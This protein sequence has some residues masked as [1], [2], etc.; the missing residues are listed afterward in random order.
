MK[1]K[2]TWCVSP[3]L[4]TVDINTQQTPGQQT[5]L[6]WL[7]H[8]Q[9]ISL[10][11][12]WKSTAGELNFLWASASP[13]LICAKLVPFRPVSFCWTTCYYLSSMGSKGKEQ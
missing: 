13:T 11:R 2:L 7:L 4:G 3:Q 6:D 9:A 12:S 10:M 1:Q 8:H 5:T